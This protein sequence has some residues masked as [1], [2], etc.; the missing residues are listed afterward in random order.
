MFFNLK[1]IS[2]SLLLRSF[3]LISIPIVLIQ[4][5]GIIVFFELHWDL[6]LKKMSNNIINNVELF[7]NEYDHY[8]EVPYGMLQ[9][10]ELVLIKNDEAK[11]YKDSKNYFVNKR[12]KQAL[13][14]ITYDSKFKTYDK[15]YFIIIINKNGNL[16]NFLVRKDKLETKTIMGFF[17]WV[18]FCSIILSII[19]YLFIKNQIKPL[20]RLGII[21]RSFG[22]GIDMPDIR[23]TGSTEIKGLIRDF[24]NM[25][26]NIN[27]TINAQKNMLAGI[28][29][30]LR[31]PLTRINLMS[32]NIE[33]KE[34]QL[35]INDNI[36]EMN[37]MIEHY[38]D[39]I[40]NE[41]EELAEKI[42]SNIFIND[43]LKQY[44]NIT[45]NKN[46]VKEI[47][48]KKIQITRALQ[49]VI[50]NSQKFAKN[51]FVSSYFSDSK[52][53]ISIEDDGPGIDLS[54]EEIVKPFVKG[55]NNLNQ[56]SGLGL[57]ILKK[58]IDLNN[59]K[60]KFDRS[61]HNGLKVHIELNNVLE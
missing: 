47:R 27:E 43:I 56:G 10:L 3:Y 11:I 55:K 18:L 30:D 15:D 37:V 20:S 2:S 46:D 12:M 26:K 19:S 13:K 44:K 50:E 32:D 31:T 41:K 35:A 52:W 36:N 21:T 38:I 33:N 23:P 57:S 17:L 9:T 14:N 54:P 60:I 34:I 58:I 6:V 51:T 53:I 24:N 8:T 28:S 25:K 29:H 48:I 61:A 59:G 7:I 5:I 42:K 39:F 45:L 22:R 40:K 4:I 16:F 1:K 49:N